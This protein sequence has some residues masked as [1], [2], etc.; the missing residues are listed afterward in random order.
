MVISFPYP[1]KSGEPY[2]V[3]RFP[4]VARFPNRVQTLFLCYHLHERGQTNARCPFGGFPCL[5]FPKPANVCGGQRKAR[6]RKTK[7]PGK[8]NKQSYFR[9]CLPSFIFVRAMKRFPSA[10]SYIDE[11]KLGKARL[12]KEQAVFSRPGLQEIGRILV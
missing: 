11:R 2:H 3:Q 6:G 10:R 7:A 8:G 1:G 4:Y 9:L 12:R 5:G